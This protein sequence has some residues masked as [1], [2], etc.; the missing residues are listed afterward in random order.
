M[1]ALQRELIRRGWITPE[2]FGIAFALARI[3]PGT[4][5]LAFSAAAGWY[6]LGFM[7]ALCAVLAATIPSSLLVVWLTRIYEAG[8]HVAWLGAVVSATIAA[9][10][11][12][13]IA[14]ALL[15]IRSQVVSN[16]W[17]MP[18]VVAG[19]AFGLRFMGVTPLEVIAIAAAGGLFWRQS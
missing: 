5:M 12:I 8:T 7:G 17:V 18:M 6:V 3:T 14:A 9:A 1:A 19:G 4:N 2:Q 10:V 15:L 13:M 11:G 16:R